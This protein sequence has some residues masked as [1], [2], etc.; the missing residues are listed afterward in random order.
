MAKSVIIIGAGIAGLSTGCYAKM[1]G[2]DAI[3]FELHNKPGGLCTSW[4][5]KGFIFDFCIHNLSGTGNVGVKRVWD[6]LGALEN[7]EILDYEIFVRVEDSKDNKLEIYTDLNKLEEHLKNIAPEDSKLIEEYINAGRALE[8]ADLFSTLGGMGSKLKIVPHAFALF[9]W[10]RIT[11]ED[12]SSRFTN[13]FLRK[14]FPHIQYNFKASELPMLINLIFLAGF[15]AIDLGWPK[16][17]SLKFS[18]NIEKRFLDLGGEIKYRSEVKKIIVENNRAVG[19]I[20]ADGS[21]HFGDVVVSAADG[22]NTIYEM[23]DGNYSNKLI[24]SY[25]QSYLEEQDFGLQIYLG[26]NRDLSSEPHALTLLFDEPVDL[27]SKG[28][29]SL[30]LEIFNSNTGLVDEGKSV[31]KVVFEGN[32]G[33]WKNLRSDMEKYNREKEKIYLKL[34]EILENRFPGIKDQVETYDITTPVTVERFTHNFHGWQPWGAK[35]GT[36]R[37]ML[38]GL[39]KTLPGL[40][41]FYMVGQWAGA[42]IGVSNAA[43]SGRDLIKELCKKDGK[44]FSP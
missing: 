37:I 33:Y 9:K 1:N 16:F 20:L 28:R 23:L 42:V 34:V 7:V 10:S 26:L 31:V 19:V 39:S 15:K 2:Y 27:E 22:H 32:Y 24:D 13:E 4:E 3:I 43:L 14:A 5:R 12:Y 29:D 17:G 25:Y 38:R 11:L 18:K 8:S 30:Y 21:E 40:K 41:N 36:M 6:E 44:K 35:E